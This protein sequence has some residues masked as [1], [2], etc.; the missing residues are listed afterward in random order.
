MLPIT[1]SVDVLSCTLSSQK[2][3]RLSPGISLDENSVEDKEPLWVLVS[4]ESFFNM[5]F[6]TLK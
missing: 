1:G 3:P 5:K 2:G 6:W 4:T